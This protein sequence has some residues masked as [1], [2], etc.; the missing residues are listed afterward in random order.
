MDRHTPEHGGGRM[1]LEATQNRGL[2]R[3][4]LYSHDSFG[5]GHLRRNLAIASRLLSRVAGLQIVLVNGSPA[6]GRFPLP[7]GLSLVSLPP[8]VKVGPEEYRS[9]DPRVEFGV[10]HRARAAIV[11]DVAQRFLPDVFLVDHA[12]QGLKG[13]LLPTFAQLRRYS[14]ATRL[15]LGLRDVIDDPAVVRSVWKQQGV[16]ETLETVYDRV[17]VY[18]DRD[19]F[20]VGDAYGLSPSVLAKTRY[21]GYLC[22]SR[23]ADAAPVLPGCCDGRPFILGAAGGG[24]D[25]FDI[26]MATLLAAEAVGVPSVIVTGPFMSSEAQSEL[27]AAARRC[28]AAHLVEFAPGLQHLMATATATVTMGGYNT[29]CE[30]ISTARPAI[31]VPRMWPRQEQ[32]IRAAMFA[33]RGLVSVVE[34]GPGLVLRLTSAL[35]DALRR[36]R[37][38][39]T[40]V[41]RGGLDRLS[42]HLLDAAESAQ[43]GLLQA[44]R[45]IHRQARMG[46]LVPA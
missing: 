20:D 2:H 21:C 36:R 4:L 38:G 3:L 32:A 24:E 27:K 13:E 23:V 30:I 35:R 29:L 28:G 18:G 41:D 15:L 12:P 14:P 25:G 46:D 5:L 26:L 19:M 45:R 6:A 17:L 37:D 40:P 9:R 33:D 8:V 16:Y 1:R 34:P 22:Q 7:K 31:I 11:A 44:P 39:T 43:P 10:V 42:T